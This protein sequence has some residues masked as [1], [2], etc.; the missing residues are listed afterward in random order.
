MPARIWRTVFWVAVIM[1]P[2]VSATAQCR[3]GMVLVGEDEHYWYCSAP[4]PAD[5]V[6]EVLSKNNPELLGAQWRFR[7]AIL[8]SVASLVREGRI[9]QWG[10]KLLVSSQGTA[11]YIC[12]SEECRGSDVA[13][14]DCSGAA[15]YGELSACF[16]GGFYRAAGTLRGLEASAAQQAEFFKHHK[17]FRSRSETPIAGDLIFFKDTARKRK[18]IT[19]VAIYVGTTR[20]GR[21]VIL[22]ASSRAGVVLFDNLAS[23]LASKI[24]GYGDSSLLFMEAAKNK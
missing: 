11:T 18:G 16:V 21:T 17:A 12:V 6:R 4:V 19:H 13:G 15:A 8:D 10:G 5:D 2:L 3:P 9:Y 23:D 22:H 20:N 14:I 1:F 24:V 7:K